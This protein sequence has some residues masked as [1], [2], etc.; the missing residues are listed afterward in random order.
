M[1]PLILVP[2]DRPNRLMANSVRPAPISP[3][4]PTTSPRLTPK[5]TFLITCRSGWMRVIDRPVLDLEHGLADLRAAL[6]EAMG[7]IAVDHA[8]DDAVFLDRLG[9]A[10]DAVD[11][12]AVAQHGDVVGDAW[13]PRSACARSGSSRCPARGM[14]SGV[15][16]ARRCRPR[17]GSR[18][19]R[20][21][22]AA[23]PAWTAPWRSRPAA[24]CRRR[25]R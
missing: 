21:G 14:P 24:A 25:D 20:P 18:S 10:V 2:Q 5:S 9:A 7:E 4:M 3:A 1:R 22:S 15:P 17:S 12:A 13:R 23:A 6:G 8:A 19:A 16:A 11:G